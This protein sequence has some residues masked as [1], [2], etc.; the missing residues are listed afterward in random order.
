MDKDA[1]RYDTGFLHTLTKSLSTWQ[2]ANSTCTVAKVPWG[3]VN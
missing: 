1:V 2:L 3:K